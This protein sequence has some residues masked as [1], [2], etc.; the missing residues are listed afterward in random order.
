MRLSFLPK[1][2]VFFQLLENLASTAQRAVKL[3]RALVQEWHLEHPAIVGLRDLE[4]ECDLIVHEIMVRLNKTFVTPIDREDIHLLAKK[5]DDLV[6]DIH[7]LSERMLLFKIESVR[8]ELKEMADVLEQAMDVAVSAIHKI[9]DLKDAETIYEECIQIHT[10]E[11]QGDRLFERALG[12]LFQNNPD[13]LEVIKWKEI[14][15]FLERAIDE[16][17]DIADVIWGIVVKYG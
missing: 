9:H 17:E 13:P 11:N 14:Y 15:D 6:D 8:G 10:L 2:K 12:S 3:F 7:A 5:I 16:C 4:H 1:D